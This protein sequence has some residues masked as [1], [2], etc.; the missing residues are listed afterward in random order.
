MRV[1]ALTVT[2]CESLSAP[3]LPWWKIELYVSR[4]VQRNGGR[5]VPRQAADERHGMA[6]LHRVI[7]GQEGA[8]SSGAM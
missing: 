8:P 3:L 4:D 6:S 5:A 7:L 1:R 2:P